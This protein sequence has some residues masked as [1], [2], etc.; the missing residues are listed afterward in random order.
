MHVVP[1]WFHDG[2]NVLGQN[3]APPDGDFAEIKEA[4]RREFVSEK[5]REHGPE[6]RQIANANRH[7]EAERLMEA[8]WNERQEIIRNTKFSANHVA[9]KMINDNIYAASRHRTLP[10]WVSKLRRLKGIRD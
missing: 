1:D 6:G 8:F 2:E 7:A 10:R 4:W 5:L 9:D 3:A